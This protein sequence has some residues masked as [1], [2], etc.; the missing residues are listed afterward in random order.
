MKFDQNAYL[1]DNK[2]PPSP[3]NVLASGSADQ[4]VILWDMSLGKPASTLTKHSDKVGARE[5]ASFTVYFGSLYVL[6][7]RRRVRTLSSVPQVQ[8][9][10]FHPF[11]AQTLLSGSYDK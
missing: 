6:P 2:P 7:M 5:A 9:L 11:E 4:T 1:T 3:R 8:S 10:S